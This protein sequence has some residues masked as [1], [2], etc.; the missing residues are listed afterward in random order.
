MM[1]KIIFGWEIGIL[2][3]LFHSL[4]VRYSKYGFRVPGRRICY[5]IAEY[6]YFM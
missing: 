5:D 4:V 6:A 1:K 2:S 3:F